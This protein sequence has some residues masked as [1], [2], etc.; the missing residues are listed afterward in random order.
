MRKLARVFLNDR[1]RGNCPGGLFRSDKAEGH[2]RLCSSP[3]L[4]ERDAVEAALASA[5][6]RKGVSFPGVLDPRDG[7]ERACRARTVPA[8][9]KHG[10][11]ER[12]CLT[13]SS[14][15]AVSLRPGAMTDCRFSSTAMRLGAARPARPG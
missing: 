2:R 5:T 7:C 13:R 6:R 3:P 15:R 1:A 14:I 12:Q 9:G 4:Q 10:Q 11:A 8:S